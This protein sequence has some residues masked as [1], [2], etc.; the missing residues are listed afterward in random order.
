MKFLYE[1]L[2]KTYMNLA[3]D[4]FGNNQKENPSV[5]DAM[6]EA[7]NSDKFITSMPDD[8]PL[9]RIHYSEVRKM[10]SADTKDRDF[11]E[12]S[13]V[14]H[15]SSTTTKLEIGKK[16]YKKKY[17][18]DERSKKENL[19]SNFPPKKQRSK[20][21]K[22]KKENRNLVSV[23]SLNS[24]NNFLPKQSKEDKGILTSFINK[25]PVNKIPGEIKVKHRDFNDS[26]LNS[27]SYRRALK[28]DKRTYFQYYFS[29]IKTREFT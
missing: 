3:D 20:S 17:T 9:A 19:K 11:N 10:K 2:L 4:I 21:F 6:Y 24:N 28:Y 14:M 23:V 25:T 16:E 22:K 5:Q 13:K 29:L 7:V 12:E 8:V 1:N 18:K 26:E 15:K 27:L